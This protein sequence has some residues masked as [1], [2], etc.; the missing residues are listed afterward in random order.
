[1]TSF[2]RFFFAISALLIPLAGAP[3]KVSAQ[4]YSVGSITISNPYSRATR[5]DAR[6]S[7]AYM[8]IRNDGEEEDRLMAVRS[9]VSGRMA[10]NERVARDGVARNRAGSL[11]T[12]R[13]DRGLAIPP[14]GMV[15]LKP[16]GYSIALEDLRQPLAEGGEISITLTFRDAGEITVPLAIGAPDAT[17]RSYLPTGNGEG[18]AEG[19]RGRLADA[20]N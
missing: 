20:G 7:G 18:E 13:I 4:D 1:M 8:M 5:N 15:A 17:G 14:R 19:G 10:L 6:F 2:S 12:R 11:E 16:G 3:A 9:G